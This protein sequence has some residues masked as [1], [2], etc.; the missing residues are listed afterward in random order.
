MKQEEHVP[1]DTLAP[2][3]DLDYARYQGYYDST[4]GIN[5]YRGIRYAAAPKRWQLPEPPVVNRSSIIEALEDPNYCPQVPDA[6]EPANLDFNASIYGDEDC[7]FL[8]VFSPKDGNNLPVLFFIHG[9]GYGSGN[10]GGAISNF[11]YLDYT[12]DNGFVLVSIQYRLGAFG[13]ASSEDI[14]K[15]GVLNVGLRDQY[16]ALQWVQKYISRFGGDPHQVTI[17]GESAG[18]GSVMLQ[19]MA[20]GGKDGTKYFKRA[21]ADSPYLPTQPKY[22]DYYPETYYKKFAELANCS[23]LAGTR[24]SSTFECLSNANTYTLQNASA[25]TSFSARWGQWAFIPVT[26]G[27]FVQETPSQQLLAGRVNG[28]QMLTGNNAN[29]AWYFVPQN[30]SSKAEFKAFIQLNYPYLSDSQLRS[31][32]NAYNIPESADS[33]PLFDSDGLHAPYATEVSNLTVGWQQAANNLYAETTFVCPSYWLA[34]AFATTGSWKYQYSVPEALH[35]K[36]LFPLLNPDTSDGVGDT[37]EV[38]VKAFQTMW[39]NFIVSGTPYVELHMPGIDS[40]SAANAES[41]KPW[42]TL[43]RYAGSK[44]VGFP[45][46]N[47]NVTNDVPKNADWRVVDGLSWE[48]GRGARCALW[49]LFAAQAQE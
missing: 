40:V 41:W 7:L 23:N 3:V 11:T 5:I 14:K 47:L 6:P 17:A 12:V 21:I 24:Y 4:Y 25:L 22:S 36:D 43:G 18:G 16:F 10:A 48:N 35:A 1:R 33:L 37:D 31:V 46:L 13:F 27:V 32:L 42:G 15:H 8:N 2:I 29:E 9:G 30:I 19:T 34:D 26:D 38:F 39:G 28:E 44:P 45:M 49:A 20:N